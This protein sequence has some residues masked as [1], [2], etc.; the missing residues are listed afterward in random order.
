[1]FAWPSV[2]RSTTAARLVQPDK[3]ALLASLL[4]FERAAAGDVIFSEGDVGDKFYLILNGVC[5]VLIDGKV[6]SL[7][8]MLRHSAT[9]CDVR[10]DA[11]V[12]GCRAAHRVLRTAARAS[13]AKPTSTCA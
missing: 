3:L 12:L 6:H 4:K 9:V 5:E 13:A 10:I 1:M 11:A 2:V 8:H 7:A